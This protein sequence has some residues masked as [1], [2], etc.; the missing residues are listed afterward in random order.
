M[1]WQALI[2]RRFEVVSAAIVLAVIFLV[3]VWGVM[4]LLKAL[5]PYLFHFNL[6]IDFLPWVTP[7][8]IVLVLGIPLYWI[9]AGWLQAPEGGLAKVVEKRFELVAGSAVY[10]LCYSMVVWGVMVLLRAWNGVDF[11]YNLEVDWL[12]A[13][14]PPWII[15]GVGS[16]FYWKVVGALGGTYP[17]RPRR[18]TWAQV[19][20]PFVI[21]GALLSGGGLILNQGVYAGSEGLSKA[22]QQDL[23]AFGIL[24]FSMGGLAWAVMLLNLWR[25]WRPGPPPTA[26][27]GPLDRFRLERGRILAQT[28]VV[29]NVALGLCSLLMVAAQYVDA[30]DFHFYLAKDI[31]GFGLPL[32]F[33]WLIF[34]LGAVLLPRRLAARNPARWGGG[35][36]VPVGPT[37]PASPQAGWGYSERDLVGAEG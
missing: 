27:L 4:V 31:W 9:Y 17:A 3:V 22:V 37:G 2:R 23:V 20:V 18:L 29:V 35:A 34:A 26:R 8:L 6:V 14:L 25:G 33:G 11:H 7:V 21:G 16:I 1:N 36:G 15:W 12:P 13:I 10:L 5:N 19:A 24:L 28:L 32:F 30:H